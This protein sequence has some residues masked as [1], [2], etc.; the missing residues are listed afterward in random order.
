MNLCFAGWR[1]NDLLANA[2]AQQ[3][4]ALWMNSESAIPRRLL[5]R[6]C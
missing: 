2:G 4:R 3:R 1:S 5:A 6:S